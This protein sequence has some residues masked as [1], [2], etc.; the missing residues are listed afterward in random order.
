MPPAPILRSYYGGQAGPGAKR[1]AMKKDV[2]VVG[3]GNTLM[4]D[5]GIG[6]AIAGHLL[7]QQ[8]K[9]PGVE[10]IDAGSGGMSLLHIIPGRKKVIV[11]DCALMGTEPGTIRRFA[12]EQV[13]SVKRLAHYSLHEADVLKTIEMSGKLGQSPQQIVIFGI[14]PQRVE[15]G[16]RL[17]ETLSQRLSEYAAT[18]EKEFGA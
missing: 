14:E 13:Q 15:P 18:I 5:E 3:L 7:S 11:V 1:V 17:S 10:F 9:Y 6:C 16:R 4:T 2:V 8:E 12:P